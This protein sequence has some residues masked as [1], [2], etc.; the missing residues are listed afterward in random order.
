MNNPT[1]KEH[2]IPQV[3][4]NGFASDDKRLFFYDLDTYRYSNQ[5]VPVRTICYKNNLYE[6]R[7]SKDEIINS[8][9]I[10]KALGLLESLF[11]K[12]K[13]AIKSRINVVNSHTTNF[14]SD[15]EINFWIVY[16]AVQILR[17]PKV[18]DEISTA[19]S[20]I[21]PSNGDKNLHRNTALFLLLPFLREL[22]PDNVEVKIFNEVIDSIGR[23]QFTIAFDEQNRLF[24]SDCPLYLYSPNQ[25][26]HDCKNIVFP[27]DSS[28]CLL[29]SEN[30]F[31]NNTINPIDK[32][33]LEYICKSISYSADRRLFRQ[34]KFSKQELYWIRSARNDR[35][36]DNLLCN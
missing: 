18:I 5:M 32:D 28:L 34:E 19:I 30:M 4:L 33:T 26:I 31:A 3:Y 2:Y 24:A 23:L 36:K 10:E 14:L 17:M 6:Y 22:E 11:A 16:I 27:I 29:F 21:V 20:K 25:R 7:N 9:I 35:L 1:K 8:N 12:N 15:E 13:N